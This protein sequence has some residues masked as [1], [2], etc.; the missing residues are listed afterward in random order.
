[1]QAAALKRDAH[2]LRSRL[3][4][5]KARASRSTPARIS[6]GRTQAYPITRPPHGCGSLA[7]IDSGGAS[8]PRAIASCHTRRSSTPWGSQPMTCS[9]V[10]V[11]LIS[12]SPAS[13]CRTASM[14]AA[15]LS[16]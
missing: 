3:M 15:C 11:G 14:S 9:P 6:G 12:S 10:A 2:L 7:W 4:T 5:F 13:R 1:M 16:C 8:T